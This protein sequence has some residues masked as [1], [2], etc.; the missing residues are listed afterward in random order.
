MDSTWSPGPKPA[1][2]VR[3]LAPGV[4]SLTVSGYLEHALGPPGEEVRGGSGVRSAGLGPGSFSPSVSGTSP[5]WS[6][7]PQGAH[8]MS[9]PAGANAPASRTAPGFGPRRAGWHDPSL[10]PQPARGVVP[11]Q[12]LG[13]H[14]RSPPPE[15]PHFPGEAAP[16]PSPHQ[17]QSHFP[18][19]VHLPAHTAL[20]TRSSCLDPT[21]QQ[22]QSCSQ[23]G[24]GWGAQNY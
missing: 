12:F 3:A 11:P 17:G 15:S 2:C 9:W 5:T 1:S 8:R 19:R 20:D 21:C 14:A 10:K 18:S 16:R 4:T 23:E 24:P 7:G 22:A 13:S 6:S